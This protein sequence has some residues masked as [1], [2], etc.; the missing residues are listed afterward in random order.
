MPTYQGSNEAIRCSLLISAARFGLTLLIL[1][2][3]IPAEPRLVQQVIALRWRSRDFFARDL[4]NATNY[5]MLNNFSHI[6][7]NEQR[8]KLV[9]I[10]N[11]KIKMP[12]PTTAE[13]QTE[14]LQLG[15]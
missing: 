12:R 7:S 13:S 2:G 3:I 11:A 6:S 9:G 15:S 4:G 8:P 14:V 5:V 10:A 1:V